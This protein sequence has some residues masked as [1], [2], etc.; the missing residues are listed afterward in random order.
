MMI[1]TEEL[2][3]ISSYK[4]GAVLFEQDDHRFI[5]LGCEEKAREGLIQ[6]NQFLL[7]SKEKNVL[8]DA[9]GVATF[10]QVVATACR[11]IE[12]SEIDVLFYSH[13]DPDVVSGMAMWLEITRANAYIG[14][15]WTQFVTHFG[16]QDVNRIKPIP[17]EGGLISLGN[18]HRIEIIPA[19][20]LHSI[21]NFHLYD[22]RSKILFS[23][24]LG[25]MVFPQGTCYLVPENFEQHSGYMAQFH[26]RFMASETALKNWV[27]RIRKLDIDLIVPQHGA[28]IIKEHIP[29]FLDWLENLRCGCDLLTEKG[30]VEIS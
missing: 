22:S 19:H 17:D 3:K 23:G 12:V 30:L 2:R 5:W 20:F 11:F 14:K 7:L 25:A 9:G 28:L 4:G 10:A 18:G 29:A 26:K 27:K 13:Q 6:V 8:M 24:D 1:P 15:Y 16:I 21:S